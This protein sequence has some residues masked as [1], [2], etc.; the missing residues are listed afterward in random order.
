MIKTRSFPGGVHP[1]DA[2]KP[3]T[4]G[5]PIEAFPAPARVVLALQ[6]NIGAPS[7]PVVQKGDVVLRGQ[8][9]AE[10]GG[11]VSVPMHSPVSGKVVE[12]GTCLHP[13][14]S[15][16]AAVIVE[17]DG[18]D[19]C[20]DGLGEA[21]S[22]AA[23]LSPQDIKDRIRDAGICGMGGAGFP[24]HVKLSPPAE[25]PIDALI[26]NGAECEPV[27]SAD[28]R[29][30]LEEPEGVMRG[31]AYLQRALGRDGK[32][33]RTIVG[34]ED[35]KPDAAE[36]LR[37]AGSDLSVDCEVV[38]LPVRYPQGGEKQLIY[39][40]LGREVPPQSERGLPMDVGVVVQNVG[41][42]LAVHEAIDK[43]T[44][45]MERV[46][47]VSGDA[48]GSPANLRA[49]LGTPLSE[50][51]ARREVADEGRKLILGGPMMGMAQFTDDFAVMKTMSGVLVERADPAE[52]GRF[53]PCIRCGRC[54]EA[55]PMRLVPSRLSTLA[56]AE[57]FVDMRTWAVVD[58]IECGCCAYECPAR[59]PIVQHVK[60]GKWIFQQELARERAAKAAA[61]KKEGAS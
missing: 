14:G 9:V 18:E 42:A 51:L 52:D 30:M 31:V 56:E 24:T 16:C 43:R 12:V 45:L 6:Q 17:N 1:H 59:R 29:V 13:T 26:L 61:E 41:T 58:C 49:R 28:H 57:R 15:R 2:Q 23:G 3:R 8:P 10:A 25:K 36:A 38:T 48:V 40:L 19:R 22:G 32:P 37:K 60:L 27:L 33:P 55:C 53:D 4:R 20:V 44:P 47:T 50:I 21:V 46:L 35:N 7:R 11:F 34:I 39:A 54:V 5:L